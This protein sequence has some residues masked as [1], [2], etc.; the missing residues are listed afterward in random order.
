MIQTI[1]FDIGNVLAE[2]A[3]RQ[4][5]QAYGYSAEVLKRIAAA[6]VGSRLWGEYD[7]GVLSDEE[8]I[9]SFVQNDPG[10]EKELRESLKNVKGMVVRY[11]YAVPWVKELKE[12]GY[13]VL[14][15]SN[16]GRKAYEECKE[17][18]DFMEYMDGGILSWQVKVIK[19]EP[20]IYQLLIEK[21]SLIPENCVFLDDLEENLEAARKFGIHTIHFKDRE[22]AGKELNQL[23]ESA[24]K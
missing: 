18:L 4:Y 14:V 2:F 21:Y 11:E 3:W 22:Q 1:I 17:A 16:F 9:E 12:R 13:Q 6:T 5:F 8:M 19:P 7:R 15:L 24:A 10:I 23:L 20:E